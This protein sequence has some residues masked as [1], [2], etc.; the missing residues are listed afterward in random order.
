MTLK[1]LPH[2]LHAGAGSLFVYTI[3]LSVPVCQFYI[4]LRPFHSEF[5]PRILRFAKRKLRFLKVHAYIERCA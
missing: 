2:P 3:R 5:A 1:K 4:P